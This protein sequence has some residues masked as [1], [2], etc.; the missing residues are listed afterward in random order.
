PTTPDGP[1]L[2]PFVCRGPMMTG[3]ALI[4]GVNPATPISA[5]DGVA[6]DDYVSSLSDF[7]RFLAIYDGIRAKH[8]KAGR[9]RTRNGLDAASCWLSALGFSPVIDTNISPYPT[10]DLRQ[11]KRLPATNQALWVFEQVVKI[12]QPSLILLHG[13]NAYT[14]FSTRFAPEF[15]RNGPFDEIV[16][17][18]R[19]GSV[20][21]SFGGTAEAYVC[22]HLRFFGRN[23][24]G[25]R[26][27]PLRDALLGP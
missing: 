10:R 19:L 13:Q 6:F 7:E 20:C 11:W 12:F 18:P 24:G 17:Q 9:T 25:Q 22:K 23:G 21:W 1:Y 27:A 26:F 3:G 8:G 4:V 16:K 2:R 5:S 15:A 14:Q